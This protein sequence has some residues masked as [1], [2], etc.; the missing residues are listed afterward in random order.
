MPHE[1][2]VRLTDR[3]FSPPRTNEITSRRVDSG[4]MKSG[5]RLVELQQL[6]LKGRELEEIILLAHRLRHA[7][8]IGANRPRR[9]VHISL[10]GDAIL[11][12]V[13]ALVDKA[14]VAQR[15]K[16]MLHAALVP[17]FG[18]ADKV[19]VAQPQPVPQPAK[20]RRDRGGKL[21]RRAPGQLR[22]SAQSSARARPCRS[23]TRSRCPAPA[24]AAQWRRRRWSSRHGPGAAAHSRSRSAWS[25]NSGLGWK[26]AG[27]VMRCGPLR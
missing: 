21:L 16:Q 25:G 24:C 3:S 19:V 22:P 12:G 27:L 20:L 4:P 5:I 8:A 9:P 2:L 7:S 6:A 23:G 15:G 13:G 18:G 26:S 1:K 14:P 17:L 10:V 11:A